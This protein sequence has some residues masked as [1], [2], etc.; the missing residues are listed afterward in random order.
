M[1]TTTTVR[2]FESFPASQTEVHTSMTG[3]RT[4]SWRNWNYLYPVNQSF[5]FEESTKLIESPRIR[6]SSL[7]FRSWLL[8]GFVSN[9]RQIFNSNNTIRLFGTQNNGFAN[10][11]IDMALKSFL[12]P[13]QPFQQLPASSATTACAFRGAFLEISALLRVSISYIA[14]FFTRPFFVVR[15]NCYIS[16][17]KIYSDDVIRVNWLWCFIFKWIL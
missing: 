15:R 12:S 16:A 13:R 9:A 8:V 10:D 5:V 1:P 4:V 3:L 6:A 17:S 14:D 2:T 7:S 11:M